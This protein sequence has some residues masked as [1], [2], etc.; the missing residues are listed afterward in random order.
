MDLGERA[1]DIAGLRLELR[2]DEDRERLLELR[3][4][5]VVVAERVVEAGEVVE[6]ASLGDDVADRLEQVARCL[7]VA[8]RE[9][10]APLPLGDEG[11]LQVHL[12]APPGVVECLDELEGAIDVLAGCFPV[13]LAPVAPRAP[14]V[15][16][17][18]QPVVRLLGLVEQRQRARELD[19][20]SRHRRERVAAHRR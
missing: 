8:A 16:V 1:Q 15:D 14:L 9:H 7:G 5:R 19:V 12:R 18:A 6:H 3:D 11:R 13:A 10:P 4:R 20:R 2:V 17:R